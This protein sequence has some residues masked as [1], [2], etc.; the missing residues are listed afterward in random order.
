MKL[1]LEII[2]Y[3]AGK[4]NPS[5][6]LALRLTCKH[7]NNIISVYKKV[8]CM[9]SQKSALHCPKFNSRHKPFNNSA[10]LPFKV[11]LNIYKMLDYQS[12]L[13]LKL[14][15][16]HF[17]AFISR[18]EEPICASLVRELARRHPY[19]N[20]TLTRLPGA[21]IMEVYI[22]GRRRTY[23]PSCSLQHIRYLEE[24]LRAYHQ[25]KSC[26]D[27]ESGVDKMQL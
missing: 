5:S 26:E 20:L 15:S 19:V 6:L 25:L 1:P 21:A 13:S 18:Y 14:T 10:Q 16:K 8:I 11:F 17:N 27:Y 9:L 22:S 24:E 12:L 4:L 2:I 3:I 23:I 7:L